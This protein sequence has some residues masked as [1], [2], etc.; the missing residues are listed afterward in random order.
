MICEFSFYWF[1]EESG[2]SG[3]KNLFY[4]FWGLVLVYIVLVYLF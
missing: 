3:F 1:F 2:F 4:F